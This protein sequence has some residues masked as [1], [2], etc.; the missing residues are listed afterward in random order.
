MTP[1][2]AGVE[3]SIKNAVENEAERQLMAHGS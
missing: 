1:A 3:K 2:H